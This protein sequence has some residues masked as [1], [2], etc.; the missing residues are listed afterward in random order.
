MALARTRGVSLHG[1]SGQVVEI[2]AD[3]SGG[4]PG[5]SFTGLADTSVVESRDRIRA[6]LVN[7]NLEWPNHKII[8]GLLPADVRKVGSRFDLAMALALL[9]AS[10]ALPLEAVADTL[11][12]AE[13][14][15]DGRLRPIR[16]VL[17][18]LVAAQRDGV[19]K[20]IVAADNAAE[21]ALVRGLDVRYARELREIVDWLRGEAD[22]L[23]RAEADAVEDE[24]GRLADLADV[25]GLAA[26]KRALEIAAAG[27]HHV[28][29]Q[30]VPG[31][32]KTMLAER[33]PG[34]LPPLGD[35][36][37]LEVTAVF[38]VAGRLGGRAR[39]VRR[40]P[41]QAPH[42]T[43]SVAALVGGGSHLARPGAISL[44]HHGVLFLDEA[45][46]FS[47]RAL[48]A[49]RQPLES[50]E[51]ILHRS[52]GAVHYPARFLLVLAANPCPCGAR[53]RDCSCAPQVRRRYQQRLSGPL[54][55]RIDLRV[56]VDPVPQG[57][58]FAPDADREA[59]AVVA[60]RVALA[61]AAAG[62]RWR[63][64]P[65]Q[66]NGQVPGPVLRT[67]PWALPPRVL[68][69]AQA[70]LSRGEISARGFDRV[71]RLAWTIA[72]LG[73][74]EVPDAGDV[75]EALYFRTGHDGSCAA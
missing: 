3:V 43:A 42:H 11:C 44:A 17:P 63:G 32:G 23:P 5:L 19:R 66:C 47:P 1:V 67:A 75:A 71:L 6:A 69:S 35:T 38:S 10:G 46:E 25:A 73:G 8:I 14:G 50:G 13:L 57:E 26:A 7:S 59:S 56:D 18:S 48:D 45:P 52:G 21:A 34:L 51:V 58:F 31:A 15:L 53:A 62:E 49:L 2:E 29:L 60:S 68:A 65:W 12:L 36:E 64:L 37:A 28:F 61:R 22:A 55:D 70:Y 41:M 72:D 9:A 24:P 16:G 40:A 74:H 4:V 39:L 20:V 30:G 33:L 27:Q 54:L